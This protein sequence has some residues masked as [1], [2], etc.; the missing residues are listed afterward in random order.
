MDWQ[1]DDCTIFTENNTI[2]VENGFAEPDHF[3]ISTEIYILDSQNIRVTVELV[4]YIAS[5]VQDNSFAKTSLSA[6]ID[7]GNGLKSDE[8]NVS[9]SQD[10]LHGVFIGNLDVRHANRISGTF[11]LVIA[12]HGY[13]N[14]K[15]R[16][17]LVSLGKL[18]LASEIN[19]YSK[20]TIIYYSILHIKLTFKFKLN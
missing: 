9:C 16:V 11:K 10:C 2:I 12:V 6:F 13:K 8:T 1:C 7:Y 18:T 3:E 17:N 15:L 19:E 4:D 20:G 14:D 5:L